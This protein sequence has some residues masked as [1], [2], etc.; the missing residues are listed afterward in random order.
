MNNSDKRADI[1]QA[2]MELIAEHGFHGAPMAD[3]ARKAGVSAG[4][5]Y[6]YFA[7]RDALIVESQNELTDKVRA[8][9]LEGYSV[10]MPVRERFFKII[11]GT[12]KYFITHHT[13]FRFSEQYFNSPYGTSRRREYSL[14]NS[15]S[16]SILMATL[17][18]GIDQKILKDLP[19]M[20]LF[21]LSTG[22]MSSLIRDHI[23]GFIT[24][25]DAMIEHTAKACWDAIKR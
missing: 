5:I 6:H 16:Q 12:L 23:S 13:H 25:D 8:A 17:K 11:K 2:A 1:M 10:N 20:V 18:D 3:I 14:G 7:S 21:S 24:L 4:T 15:D 19:V 22:P 9:I